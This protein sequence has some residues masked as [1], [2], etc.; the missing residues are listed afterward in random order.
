M[1]TICSSL[2]LL[3][4]AA[5]ALAQDDLPRHGVV[6]L[7]VTAADQTKPPGADNP[8]VVQRVVEES[9]GARAGF[10]KGDVIRTIDGVPVTAPIQ[11]S[12]AI[13][14]HLAGEVVRVA[15]SRS[16][17][18]LTLLPVLKPRPFETSPNAEV[19]YRSVGVRGVR[20]R[21]IVTRPKG[22][23]RLPAVLLMQ[24]LGCESVDGI[25]RK[26]GYGAVISAFEE[27]AF[28]TMRVEKTG[29]G[30]S[31]GPPC[32]DLS[33]TPDLE[34]EGYLA[35]LRALKSYD[36]VDPQKVFV[37]AHSM[38]PV[39]G[40]LAISQEPVRGFLAVET[41]GTS[42]FE[43]DLERSRVQ[44]GLHSLPD[45]VD[46]AVREYE[47]C[48]HR[49]YVEKVRPEDLPATLGCENM[50]APFGA[51]PY[52]YMQA[53]A[54]ISLGKQWKEADFPVLVIYGTASPVTTAH[55]SHYLVELIN[56]FHPGRASYAEVPGMG[57][58]LARYESQQDYLDRVPGSP[59]PFH[60]GLIDV[61]MGWVDALLG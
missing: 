4:C 54:D 56:R 9:A 36:F 41:V 26:T 52:T 3:A 28:V 23:G 20:R 21:V 50:T 38:G 57:H 10:Q 61:L 40:S 48:S 17:Q 14:R 6:G 42:W 24:G 12:Q 43:Y 16:A 60:T 39:V 58:D 19:L 1:R 46:R 47:V 34:A 18:Q 33:A 11:F 35:A 22:T 32:S 8:P 59:H 37:F 15:I 49:F 53:V 44:H 7:L 13:A 45:Q 29:E 2:V 30:D 27:H 51:V 25:D 5:L 55:Q 31:Q